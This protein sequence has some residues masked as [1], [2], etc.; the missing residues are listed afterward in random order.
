[1]ARQGT[2]MEIVLKAK[3]S[4]NTQFQFLDFGHHLNPYYKHL[5]KSIQNGVYR[6]ASERDK[7]DEANRSSVKG[8]VVRCRFAAHLSPSPTHPRSSESV[9]TYMRARPHPSLSLCREAIRQ[10]ILRFSMSQS[11]ACIHVHSCC[12]RLPVTDRHV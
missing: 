7:D 10:L 6:P 1:M 3:Q 5:V 12:F 11:P 8:T 2:Q 4:Q 9:H